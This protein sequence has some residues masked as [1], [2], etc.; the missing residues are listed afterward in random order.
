MPEE[1]ERFDFRV[2]R[3]SRNFVFV[4]NTSLDA[5]AKVDAE[6]LEVTSIEVGDRPTLVQTFRDENLA[7]VLNEGSD[8]VTIIRA[9][10]F[11]ND[12][13]LNLRIPP[14]MNALLIAPKGDYALAYYD[15]DRA[16][17]DP[18]EPAPE[19]PP[20]Q[21][22]AL[23]RLAEGQE[24]VFNLT[25]GFQ[26]L[27][28]EF[29]DAGERAFIITR[30]GVSALD[31][32]SVD[33]DLALPPV[34]VDAVVTQEPDPDNPDGLDET[35]REVEI[36]GDGRFAFVRTA[37]LEGINVVDLQ[38]RRSA[39]VTLAG[40]PTDLDIVPGEN[41]AVAVV[42]QTGELAV[43]E[44][45]AVLDDPSAVRLIDLEG[46]PAGLAELTPDATRALVFTGAEERRAITVVD[47][48]EE[49]F[50][51]YPLRKGIRGV[52]I[53]PSG[54]EAL[55]FHTKL[56][57]DPVPGEDRDDFIDK[58]WAYSLFDINTGRAKLETVP[59]EP[60][61]FVYSDDGERL[62]LL[63]DD[64]AQNVREVQIINMRSFRT[65][66][67]RLGSPPEHIGLIPNDGGDP[68]V[69][70]SQEHPVGRMTFIN[71][72]SG[73]VKTVTGFQLNSLI[74]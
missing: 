22:V 33:G 20:F 70:V 38:D 37:G 9:G 2:P 54:Q 14:D 55:I 31:F 24:A 48:V 66:A 40:I 52:A 59:A 72:V 74:D 62:Y 29:D 65:D 44:L 21:D 63:L 34:S 64:P 53:S 36:T 6:T 13:V 41:R 42:R 3:S 35:D 1:E 26:V 58:S 25:V 18:D 45:P 51:L 67:L 16:A 8:E 73:D 71:E 10:D 57:G 47:L 19:A 50:E 12:Y 69:Y 7:V 49:T 27:D 23:V 46:E 39:L 17:S 32:A 43:L 4:A 68:R 15:F 11:D 5:V 30:S 56:P 61:E 60:G 28:V